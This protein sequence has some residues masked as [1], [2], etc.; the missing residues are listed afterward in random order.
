MDAPVTTCD[1]VMICCFRDKIVG[2]ILSPFGVLLII[3]LIVL[4]LYPQPARDPGSK[5]GEDYLSFSEEEFKK[6]W[7]KR[8]K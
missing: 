2:F 3:I 4:L 8:L 7:D 5:S 1:D 6:I